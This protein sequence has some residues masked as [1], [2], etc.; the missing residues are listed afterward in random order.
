[1]R[2]SAHHLD[3]SIAQS[4]GREFGLGDDGGEK[5]RDALV[6]A[7]LDAFGIDQDQAHLRGR[8]LVEQRHDH[9]IDGHG[10]AAASGTGDEHVGHRGQVGDDD[11]AVNVFAHGEGELRA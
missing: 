1:M 9:G 11:A 6:H 8:S 3:N 4:V 2:A 10:F 5:V 7:K